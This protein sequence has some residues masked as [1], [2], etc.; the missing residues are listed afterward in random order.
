MYEQK[1]WAIFV[2]WFVYQGTACWA[3]LVARCLSTTHLWAPHTTVALDVLDL[4]NQLLDKFSID[5]LWS[6]WCLRGQKKPNKC[7][8]RSM[9][10]LSQ[11]SIE[12]SGP[13]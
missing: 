13:A 8:A 11:G 1:L 2:L 6:L 3:R 7:E 4:T 5:G 12:Y 10:M 9:H